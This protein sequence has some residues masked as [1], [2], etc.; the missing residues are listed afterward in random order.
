[1]GPRS[2]G[3]SCDAPASTAGMLRS[4]AS[5]EVELHSPATC[6]PPPARLVPNT[7]HTPSLQPPYPPACPSVGAAR[8]VGRHRGR[9]PA[10]AGARA[11]HQRLWLRVHGQGRGGGGR[12]RACVWGGVAAAAHHLWCLCMCVCLHVCVCA[13]ACVLRIVCLCLS[14]VGLV[15]ATV[16]NGHV[17]RLLPASPPGAHAVRPTACQTPAHSTLQTRGPAACRRFET[18]T[19]HTH[20]QISKFP[21]RSRARHRPPNPLFF[22]RPSKRTPPLPG[23]PHEAGVVHHPDRQRRGLRG[24]GVAGAAGPFAGG[25][26]AVCLRWGGVRKF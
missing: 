24:G 20:W 3:G 1:M 13:C 16:Q 2:A 15:R 21:Q 22:L 12:S 26:G 19:L 18:R 11:A 7:A 25:A 6:T 8:V 17:S 4:Q 9:P 23:P 10:A 5:L 14:W